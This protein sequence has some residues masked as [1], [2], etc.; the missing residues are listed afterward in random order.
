MIEILPIRTED[1]NALRTLFLNVRQQ[2]FTWKDTSE[3]VLSDFDEE[4]AGEDILVAHYNKQI[5][6]FISVWVQDHFIH[7]LYVATDLQQLKIGSQ[8][9][10]AVLIKYNTRLTLK[11]LIENKNAISF[12]KKHGFVEKETV[13]LPENSYI[14]FENTSAAII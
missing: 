7:H 13:L 2:T 5:A 9:L 4:T 11:C 3:L 12:Y 14:L 10:S 6:G 8:L 1:K